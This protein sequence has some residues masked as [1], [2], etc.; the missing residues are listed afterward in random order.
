MKRPADYL[1][2]ALI[3]LSLAV[4]SAVNAAQTPKATLD[5][6]KIISNRNLFRKLGW[7]PPTEAPQFTL[8]LTAVSA[9]VETRSASAEADFWSALLGR[10]PEPP[11]PPPEPYPDRALIVQNG[12]NSVFYV[13]VGDRVRNYVVKSIEKGRVTLA[14]EDGKE[15]QTLTLQEVQ[16]TAMGGGGGPGG[17]GGGPGGGGR[18]RGGGPGGGGVGG[19]GQRRGTFPPGNFPG[20]MPPN[21]EEMRRRFQNMTPE[22]REQLRNQFRQ[23]GGGQGGGQEGG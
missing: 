6:Y 3:L 17:P 18:G 19:G 8:L 2:R 14:T 4:V 9:P 15:T 1:Y 7:R 12:S 22:E 16:W 23:R 21:F 10:K 11:A 5:Y 20:G 13:G